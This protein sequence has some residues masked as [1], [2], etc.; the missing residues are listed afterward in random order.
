MPD[1]YLGDQD[2]FLKKESQKKKRISI[3][4]GTLVATIKLNNTTLLPY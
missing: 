3:K 1:G 2:N 4:N